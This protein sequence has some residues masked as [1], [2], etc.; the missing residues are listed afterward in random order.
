MITWSTFIYFAIPAVVLSLAAAVWS[1]CANDHWSA[2]S[3]VYRRR[4][5]TALALSFASLAVLGTFIVGLWISLGRPPMRTM[6]ETRLWYSFFA[7]LSGL[8]TY[9]VWRYRWI[10]SFSTVLATVFM[11]L[12]I[13]R[14]EIHD[15]TLMP[16][17][18][19]AWFIPH[20]TVYM[21]SYSL[22]G[23]A[24]ILAVVGLV[25]R[26]QDVLP[27]TDTL[28]YIGVAFLTFGMLSGS[29][30]AKQA[31]GHYWAW[32]PKETWALVTWLV[33][34]FYIHLRV[35]GRGSRRM[36]CFLLVFGFMCLQMC[37][38]GINYLPAAQDSIHIYNR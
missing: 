7:L 5:V 23:C 37:W 26:S 38:W 19:S 27:A 13:V 16:A 15:Q 31:W 21:F 6:G 8:L 20:V 12:N 9:L 18:Q 4:R 22:L 32:D 11:V 10:L 1:L 2:S 34:V 33:Y 36:L 35:T 3:L 14:P 30:W 17:L 25:S 29:L 24:F 28:I